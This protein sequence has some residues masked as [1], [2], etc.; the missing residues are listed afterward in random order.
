MSVDDVCARM[1]RL[2]LP[3]LPTLNIPLSDLAL[4][5]SC[6]VGAPMTLLPNRLAQNVSSLK[7]LI[8]RTG[9]GQLKDPT[10]ASILTWPGNRTVQAGNGAHR[11]L[12]L[13]VVKTGQVS[14]SKRETYEKSQ[15]DTQ[16]GSAGAD[17]NNFW[18]SYGTDVF[19]EL[20]TAHGGIFDKDKDVVIGRDNAYRDYQ[21]ANS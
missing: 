15:K 16:P 12:K 9:S 19:T 21:G 5:V 1:R 8:D 4:T 10:K 6:N 14:V 2:S 17:A 18:W 3:S 11:P 13:V 7:D 20:V